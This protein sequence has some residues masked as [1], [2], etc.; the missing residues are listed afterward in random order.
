MEEIDVSR[1][2]VF[3]VIA[4][5]AIVALTTLL[6]LCF[7]LL[8]L[9]NALCL[10]L[11]V[12]TCMSMHDVDVLYTETSGEDSYLHLL[13]QFGVG[14]KSPLEF[15]VTEFC[16]EVV[17]IVHLLHHQAVLTILLTPERYGEQNL[18]GVEHVVVV[19]QR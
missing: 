19:E 15:E 14:G 9:G 4:L 6:T 11:C 7:F 1:T 16:H 17:D 10:F 13:A 5:I 3:E 18:L 12:T 2:L 8:L